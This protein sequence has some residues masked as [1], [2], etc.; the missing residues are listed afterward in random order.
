MHAAS[1]SQ[2]RRDGRA[3]LN[4]LYASNPAA[5]RLRDSAKGILIFPVIVKA[6]LIIGGQAGDGTLF[7][8]GNAV[9]YYRSIAAS[10]GL[11]AG[12]QT[13]SY[14]L[15]FMSD[16]ALDYLHKSNGWEIGS[17][18]SVV[19]LDEGAGKTISST[20]LHKGVYAFI[21]GQEGLM[22]GL[23]LQGTKITPIHP[24]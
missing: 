13:F 2:M 9:R 7:E 15:F 21:F 22:A 5:R 20:T 23:G 17:G 12:G 8:N 6:G 4:R 24:R 18:P 16:D 1:A 10:Y 11:Q 3:A 19:V 14:A